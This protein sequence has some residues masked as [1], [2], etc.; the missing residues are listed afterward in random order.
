[1]MKTSIR[2]LLKRLIA[3]LRLYPLAALLYGGWRRLVQPHTQG[4]LVA[5]WHGQELLLVETSYRRSWSLPGGGIERGETAR[6]AAVR[7]LA[8][9][10][11]LR[12]R[13]EQLLE[14]WQICERG[15]GGLN[16]VTIFTLPLRTRPALEVDGLEIV[17]SHWLSREQALAQ[18]LPG[19]V[20]AYLLPGRSIRP[21]SSSKLVE[22]GTC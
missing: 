14:P 2:A 21:G 1:M 22:D 7:E 15:P 11:G 3:R 9:E 16:T 6:Q 19:H 18:E 12:V 4:A 13:A 8:E 5:I 17:A 20:R 10:V